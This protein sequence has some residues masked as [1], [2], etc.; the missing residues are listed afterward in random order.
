[1]TPRCLTLIAPFIAAAALACY[2]PDVTSSAISPGPRVRVTRFERSPQGGARDTVRVSGF[3]VSSDSASVVLR[4]SGR[5]QGYPRASVLRLERSR[6]LDRAKGALIGSL[7]GLVIGAVLGATADQ[8]CDKPA[9]L[10][11]D[12]IRWCDLSNGTIKLGITGALG[13]SLLGFL[14][15]R[16]RWE[17]L[18]LTARP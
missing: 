18:E 6:G 10:G 8:P 17:P 14:H 11:V 9:G 5:D 7:T 15:G 12:P 2:R 13:G 4:S 1:M 16:E 3:L